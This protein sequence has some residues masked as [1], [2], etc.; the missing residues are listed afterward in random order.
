M[1]AYGATR[2]KVNLDTIQSADNFINHIA[3]RFSDSPQR[4]LV[5]AAS[6]QM[7]FT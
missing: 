6:P 1:W 3:C 7:S 4:S 2:I 5:L